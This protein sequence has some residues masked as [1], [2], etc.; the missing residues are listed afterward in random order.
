MAK[1][2]TDK[3]SFLLAFSL[4]FF[5]PFLLPPF[6]MKLI[7]LT[8]AFFSLSLSLI[9]VM[10]FD[11]QDYVHTKLVL[12]ECCTVQSRV[13]HWINF[14]LKIE[15]GI[16]YAATWDYVLSKEFRR[17]NLIICA[18]FVCGFRSHPFFSLLLIT[19]GCINAFISLCVPK[20]HQ[21]FVRS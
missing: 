13:L 10:R 21:T 6:Q 12:F 9:Q 8:G 15:H 7:I 17:F 5:F 20:V 18:L 16:N 11:L 2:I 3:F 1:Q 14:G 19:L 4:F